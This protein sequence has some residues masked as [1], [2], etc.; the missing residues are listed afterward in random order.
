MAFEQRA[1]VAENLENLILCH[2]HQ[3]NFKA[4]SSKEKLRRGRRLQAEK[5]KP[6]ILLAKNAV[7]KFRLPPA[8]ASF[9]TAS[10]TG[11]AGRLRLRD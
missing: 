1:A 3:F 10:A 4:G 2:R 11:T 9:A 5:L 6:L 8:S 7:L